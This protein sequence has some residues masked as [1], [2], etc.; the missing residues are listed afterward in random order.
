MEAVAPEGKKK[1]GGGSHA[2]ITR[3]NFQL[4]FVTEITKILYTCLYLY[5]L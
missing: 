5:T 2:Y 1:G 3:Q 4:H